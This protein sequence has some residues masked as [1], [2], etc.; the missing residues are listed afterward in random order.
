[1]LEKFKELKAAVTIQ[2]DFKIKTLRTNNSGEYTSTEIR[3]FFK[4]KGIRHETTVPHPLQQN[5]IAESKNQTLQEAAL[6]MILR[7]PRPFGQRQCVMQPM[8]ETLSSRLQL[9]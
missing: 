7:C 6:S 1:M 4:E 8:F 3:N 5:G 9:Q 2:T